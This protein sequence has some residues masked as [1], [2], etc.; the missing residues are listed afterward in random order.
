MDKTIQILLNND[1]PKIVYAGHNMRGIRCLEAIS[2]NEQISVV[3]SIS[4]PVDKSENGYYSSIQKTSEN[5]KIPVYCPN[6]INKQEFIDYIIDTYNPDLCLLVGYPQI[7]KNNFFNKFSY[8]CI[9]CH[10]SPLP[11][12]RGA[13]P[14]NWALIR[15]EKQW[16]IS[17][18][19]IDQGIDT[20][21]ILAQDF[22][23]ISK[24]DTIKTLTEKVNALYPPL[25]IKTI[26]GMVKGHLNVI[27]QDTLSGSFCTK[28][29]PDDGR[30]QWKTMNSIEIHNLV[31]AL[32][33]PYPGAF[34]FYKGEKLKIWETALVQEE[35]IGIPGRIAGLRDDGVIVIA[36]D[37]GLLVKKISPYN[38]STNP[39]NV[40]NKI[41]SD[42]I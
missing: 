38:G 11:F 37:R 24:N 34:T 29:F 36:K 15:G 8:G 25:I 14:L 16:G 20:G 5:L 32:T 12:Y 6:N 21:D 1:I 31:R 28:R 9:N 23:T 22:F 4:Q 13:A 18:I 40:L 39:R 17:I 19:K 30:I 33:E 7:I 10:A 2:S 42:L 26:M 35:Y 41:G 3:A 27:K